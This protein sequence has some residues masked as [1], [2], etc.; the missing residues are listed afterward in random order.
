[1]GIAVAVQQWF[2]MTTAKKLAFDRRGW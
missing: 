2:S 1:V